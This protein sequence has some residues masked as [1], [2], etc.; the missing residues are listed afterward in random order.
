MRLVIPLL[1]LTSLVRV[2]RVTAT[3]FCSPKSVCSKSNP[4]PSLS[5]AYSS[6]A[7]ETERGDG[8]GGEGITL[9]PKVSF[10]DLLSWSSCPLRHTAGVH[11]QCQL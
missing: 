11:S 6:S 5:M 3:A 8:I 4:A 9:V 1:M 2:G 7:L 10:V